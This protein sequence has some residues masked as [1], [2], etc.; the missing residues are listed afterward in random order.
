MKNCVCSKFLH[1]AL[2]LQRRTF[3]SATQRPNER[4]TQSR[5]LLVVQTAINETAWMS[6]HEALKGNINFLR[7][8]WKHW[9][10]ML[11]ISTEYQHWVLMLDHK[12]NWDSSRKSEW[13]TGIADG[14]RWLHHACTNA[15][16]IST[17]VTAIQS[18]CFSLISCANTIYRQGSD[19]DLIVTK[20]SFP[21]GHLKTHF[22]VKLGL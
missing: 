17:C 8:E 22:I 3:C 12:G 1:A 6:L 9:V 10:L 14:C 2:V 21:C 13:V 15:D 20:N 19:A 18:P 7:Q 5:L 4:T 16:H 11:D